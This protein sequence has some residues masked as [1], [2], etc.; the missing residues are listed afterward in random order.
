M[1]FESLTPDQQVLI[2]LTREKWQHLGLST[3]P[4]DQQQAADAVKALY[5]ALGL[6]E[7]EIIFVDSPN[8]ALEYIWNLVQARS[9]NRLGNAIDSQHWGKLYSSLQLLLLV[10]IPVILQNDLHSAFENHFVK[11]FTT[12]LKQQLESQWQDIAYQQIGNQ[13]REL[14]KN[15][16]SSC[17]KPES[18]VAGGSYFDFCIK[19]FRYHQFQNTLLILETF[20]RNCGWTFFFENICIVCDR[21]QKINFDSDN[22]LHA[23]DEAA[24]M[25]KDGY[26]LSANHG[27]I[28][29]QRQPQP[30]DDAAWATLLEKLNATI[31]D[32]WEEYKLLYTL[33]RIG[34]RVNVQPHHFLKATNSDTGEVRLVKIPLHI[35]SA[36]EA[37]NWLNRHQNSR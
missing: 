18:L 8:A 29:R 25:F 24:I 6:V 35:T 2:P 5:T 9:D 17:Q 19:A 7:P 4:V 37:V 32:S 23:E 14:I 30:I 13:Y 15:I 12:P 34:G 3:E 16:F 27:Q 1:F 33:L 31:I 22:C 26:S 11:Q 10:Q 21:P 36:R 28:Q 20:A